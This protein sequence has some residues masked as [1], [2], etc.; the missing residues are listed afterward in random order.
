MTR[1]AHDI[2]LN[3]LYRV[4]NLI[5]AKYRAREA[6]LM[7]NKWPEY[8][9]LTP[10]D[11]NR[12]F[13]KSFI[14]AY[15]NYLRT[16]IDAT[17]AADI[18]IGFKLNFHKRNAH[19]TQLYVARQKADEIGLP[20][21]AYLEFIFTF[22]AA[23]RYRQPPQPNQLWPNEK[24]LDAW[25]TKIV[26]FWNND[27]HCLEL[28]RM[29]SMPQYAYYSDRGLPA[30]HRFRSELIDMV[31]TGAMPTNRF[32]AKHV[33]E[34]QYFRID[35][36]DFLERSAAEN[37]ERNARA[38]MGIGLLTPTDYR[39]LSKEDFYQSC[40]GVPGIVVSDNPVCSSCQ[41]RKECELTRQSVIS[42]SLSETGFAD[43]IDEA[44]RR[45][46]RR[47]V[48]EYRARQRAMKSKANAAPSPEVAM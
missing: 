28:N 1:T 22:A 10:W 7:P 27:R 31:S 26:E 39:T 6:E 45:G 41:Q 14:E 34:R 13:H 46:N 16:N 15:K 38:D 29:K 42:R 3:K 48:N 19:L 12:L 47:R 25:L 36:C 40:F 20:Y 35:S 43:P 37:A 24:K 8:R 11:A 32:V 44:D 4:L 18:K 23:R 5:P 30:Q 2:R 9:F 21:P 33:F 17:T